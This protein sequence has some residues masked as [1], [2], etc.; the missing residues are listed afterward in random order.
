MYCWIVFRGDGV[1]DRRGDRRGD[2]L[3]D[4]FGDRFGDRLFSRDLLAAGELGISLGVR[5]VCISSSKKKKNHFSKSGV[6]CSA[7]RYAYSDLLIRG[8]YARKAVEVGQ[9][10]ERVT[11][12]VLRPCA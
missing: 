1:G 11:L 7:K 5:F 9:L 2:R 10:L 12:V 4:R 3:G 8:I 6:V